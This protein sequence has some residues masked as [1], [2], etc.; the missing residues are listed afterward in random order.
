MKNKIRIAV[1]AAVVA[2]YC[3]SA[4]ASPATDDPKREPQRPNDIVDVSRFIP[5]MQFDIRYFS[6]HNFVG[7][8][9]HGYDA[10]ACLLTEAAASALKNR[11]SPPSTS[12]LPATPSP[13][14]SGSAS[15]TDC[16]NAST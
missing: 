2:C 9:I 11:P 14:A 10:P 13:T 5:S 15:N 6:N 16:T 7:R 3:A 4:S 8:P 1:A 12:V